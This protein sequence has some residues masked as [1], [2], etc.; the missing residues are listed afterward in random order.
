MARRIKV[1]EQ[2]NKNQMEEKNKVDDKQIRSFVSFGL[3]PLSYAVGFIPE[4]EYFKQ[5]ML[6]AITMIVGNIG[7]MRTLYGRSLVVGTAGLFI[8]GSVLNIL[9]IGISQI[10]ILLV[11]GVVFALKMKK[12]LKE[13]K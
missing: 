10:G 11:L 2:N 8:L 5:I 4:M 1:K 12:E 3:F 6:F 9:F 13:L 7:I